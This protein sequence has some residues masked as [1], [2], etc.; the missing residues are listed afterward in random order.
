MVSTSHLEDGD[1]EIIQSDTDPWIKLLNTLWDIRFEQLTPPTEDKVTQINL[2]D[3][4][5]PKPMFISESLSSSEK[6]DLIS[7]MREYI[8]VFAWN[9]ED[10]L[11]LEPQVVMHHL[12]INSDVKPVK[13]Q[14]RRFCPEI[15]EAIQSEVKKLIDSGF[16]R[17]E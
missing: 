12:N 15:M 7:L 13:Q 8:D 10:M 11:R 5:N 14:Q 3:E 16:I 6:E 2:G 9:Y 1:E 17:E 4:A